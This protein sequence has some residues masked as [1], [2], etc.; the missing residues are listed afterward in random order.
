MADLRVSGATPGPD[1][2]PSSAPGTIGRYHLAEPLG[3]GPT[4]EVFRAKVYG[5]AG[6]ERQF[7]LKRIHPILAHDPA[8]AEA[9]AGAARLYGTLENPGIARMYEHGNAAGETFVAVELV[10]G[11]DLS[12]LLSV[13]FAAGEPLPAGG[14]LHLILQV[15]RA[16][17][18]GHRHG[19]LHLGICPT[20]VV[21]TPDGDAKV[22]D[23]GLLRARLG[24][25]PAEDPTLAARLPYLTPEQLVGGLEEPATDVFQLASL[26]V[27]LLSGERIFGA[28]NRETIAGKIQAGAPAVLPVPPPLEGPLL[29][30][31]SSSSQERFLDA[32]VL[33]DALDAAAKQAAISGGRAEL[34]AIIKKAAGNK[35]ELL[36][37]GLSGAISFPLP[38]PPKAVPQVSAGRSA[39]GSPL[40]GTMEPPRRATGEAAPGQAEDPPSLQDLALA[41]TQAMSAVEEA[42]VAG[43]VDVPAAPTREGPEE[44]QWVDVPAE[45]VEATEAVG[46][47][48]VHDIDAAP[49]PRG[50]G[51]VRGFRIRRQHLLVAGGAMA[52]LVLLLAVGITWRRGDGGRTRGPSAS[53]ATPAKPAPPEASNGGVVAASS[54]GSTARAAAEPRPVSARP[55][56]P[57]L[58]KLTVTSTPS[59]AAVYIDGALKGKTP[60]DLPGTGDRHKLAVVLPGRKLHRSE[61]DGHGRVDIPL[62]AAE[63]FSGPAGIKVKCKTKDRFYVIVN[64]KDTGELCPTERIGVALGEYTVEVYDPV[65]DASSSHAVKVKETRFSERV[66]VDE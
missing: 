23:F 40:P 12:Y 8:S 53:T 57:E 1:P 31:L 35:A 32:S 61:V 16:V 26:A 20:N 52:M 43:V 64:G 39:K 25:R 55:A 18:F 19:V 7:A 27:E 2:L 24:G 21:V 14:A 36:K 13:T 47:E 62:V 15:A 4:G 50:L 6:F 10:P 58:G 51:L 49:T 37:Q 29:R 9:I 56:A 45:V 22:C 59:G 28:T 38:A 33:A 34:A 63:K 5:V 41:T 17:G 44:P 66:K 54:P 65:T 42:A 11:I 3:G 48:G 60:L 30:A 46:N